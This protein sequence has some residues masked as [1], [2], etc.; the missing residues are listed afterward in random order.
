MTDPPA[1]KGCKSTLGMGAAFTLAA[2]AAAV[3]LKRKD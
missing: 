1:K 2:M 3:A